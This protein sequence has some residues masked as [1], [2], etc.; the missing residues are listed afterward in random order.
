MRK[1]RDYT[2]EVEAIDVK[3]EQEAIALMR[4]HG[5]NHLMIPN[6]FRPLD[7]PV[8]LT[9]SNTVISK[10]ALRLSITTSKNLMVETQNHEF[11]GLRNMMRGS[12]AYIYDWLYSHYSRKSMEYGR[13][14]IERLN[15][16]TLSGAVAW[17]NRTT[18]ADIAKVTDRKRWKEIEDSVGIVT[19]SQSLAQSAG[20][21]DYDEN[22]KYFFFNAKDLKFKSFSN[23]Q[24]IADYFGEEIMRAIH[25]N[26]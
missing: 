25:Q 22:D 10:R 2:D 26:Y 20:E 15:G 13:E 4:E 12:M 19:M 24:Q 17:V 8:Q 5:E 23:S 7:I 18:G 1:H 6:G 11:Y 16:M 3:A 9:L 14:C 21:G